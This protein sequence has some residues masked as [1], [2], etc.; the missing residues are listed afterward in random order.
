[1]KNIAKT[2]V[3]ALFLNYSQ[4]VQGVRLDRPDDKTPEQ[5][6]FEINEKLKDTLQKITIQNSND[7]IAAEHAKQAAL[8]AFDKAKKAGSEANELRKTH[9]DV[10]VNEHEN[11]VDSPI[12]G[13][14]PVKTKLEHITKH[15]IEPKLDGVTGNPLIHRFSTDQDKFSSNNPF[16]P[17]DSATPVY[18]STKKLTT[19]DGKIIAEANDKGQFAGEPVVTK[20]AKE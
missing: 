1:M 3:L 18:T 17:P 5:K 15:T 13:V 10:I 9:P 14:A 8:D 16:A 2:L 6:E 4:D 20:F 7:P 19:T 11:I 12:F